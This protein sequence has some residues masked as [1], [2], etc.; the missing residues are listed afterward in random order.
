MLGLQYTHLNQGWLKDFSYSTDKI[1]GWDWKLYA[2]GTLVAAWFWGNAFYCGYLF[3]TVGLGL[4]WAMIPT[5]TV[6]SFC[7]ITYCLR[8]THYVHVHHWSGSIFGLALLGF[9]HWW[10][11]CLS[12][13]CNGVWVEGSAR[14]G[15]DSNWQ[16][17]KKV[18]GK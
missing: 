2:F 17:R 6:G 7:L 11:S 12:G 8:K 13:W 14:W 3:Y 5:V 4:Y 18:K 16:P 15:Y 9:P 10:M 1:A